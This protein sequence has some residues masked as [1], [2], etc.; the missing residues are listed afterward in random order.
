LSNKGRLDWNNYEGDGGEKKK[1]GGESLE[2]CWL[3][4]EKSIVLWWKT[5]T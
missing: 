5:N 3:V 4:K 2:T 1:A